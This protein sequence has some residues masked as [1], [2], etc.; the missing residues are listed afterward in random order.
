M[1]QWAQS[2]F[3]VD[4]NWMAPYLLSLQFPIA[5]SRLSLQTIQ[6]EPFRGAFRFAITLIKDTDQHV[7]MPILT[8]CVLNENMIIHALRYAF[9]QVIV[10]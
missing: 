4:L 6:T 3:K 5:V 10:Q 9:V 2:T 7:S 8:H 1:R